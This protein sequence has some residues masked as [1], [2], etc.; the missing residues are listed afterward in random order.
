MW[1]AFERAGYKATNKIRPAKVRKSH[2]RKTARP[3][4]RRKQT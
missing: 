1:R 4:R 3:K 2:K